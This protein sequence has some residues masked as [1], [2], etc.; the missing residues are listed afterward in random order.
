MNQIIIDNTVIP[1]DPTE[2][3]SLSLLDVIYNSIILQVEECN[4]FI[5]NKHFNHN[6]ANYTLKLKTLI[7]IYLLKILEYNPDNVKMT[8]RKIRDETKTLN[9]NYNILMNELFYKHDWVDD[10]EMKKHLCRCPYIY[11]YISRNYMACWICGKENFRD[12]IIEKEISR[13]KNINIGLYLRNDATNINILNT[14]PV[15]LS[16]YVVKYI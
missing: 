13:Q 6:N 16:K 14:L 3:N 5:K 1:T 11:R 7:D 4:E 15:D 9:Q 12:D 10:T 8:N 2:I